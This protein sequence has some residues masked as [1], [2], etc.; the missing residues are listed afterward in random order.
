MSLSYR[1]FDIG[2]N[3]VFGQGQLFCSRIVSFV[4]KFQLENRS[5]YSLAFAQRHMVKG[6]VSDVMNQVSVNKEIESC[7]AIL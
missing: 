1:T 5:R 2:I 6:E 4:T 7:K 3:S